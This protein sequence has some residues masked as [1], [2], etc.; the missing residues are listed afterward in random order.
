MVCTVR[1][2]LAVD[3]LPREPLE[4][5]DLEKDPQELRYEVANPKFESIRH[6]LANNYLPKLLDKLDYAKLEH[7]QDT[8][9]R[10]P[11]QGGWKTIEKTPKAA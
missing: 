8:L 11:N 7:Y 9:R 10:D 3:S 1:F 2:K 4:L 6:E 5:Y